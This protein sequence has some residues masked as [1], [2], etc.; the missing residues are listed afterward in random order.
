MNDTV[1]FDPKQGFTLNINRL[2][3][4]EGT[5]LCIADYNNKL[6]IIKYDVMQLGD[7]GQHGLPSGTAD[8]Y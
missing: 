8:I 1:R 7:G 2:H 6:Q 3:Q 4:P 5:Y